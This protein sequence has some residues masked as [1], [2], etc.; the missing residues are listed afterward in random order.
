MEKPNVVFS[1]VASAPRGAGVGGGA[2]VGVGVGAVVGVGVGRGV[3]VG[4]TVGVTV[5]KGVAVGPADGTGDG[6]ALGSGVGVAEL[7]LEQEVMMRTKA[8]NRDKERRRVLPGFLIIVV[9][10]LLL[11]R[12]YLNTTRCYYRFAV[13]D[14]PQEGEEAGALKEE[15]MTLF[16]THHVHA[17]SDTAAGQPLL[18]IEKVS[19]QFAAR[20]GLL[21]RTIVRAVNDVSLALHRGETVAV[22][23]ESGSGKTTLGRASLGLVEPASGR[24][25]FDGKVV[26][27]QTESQRKWFRRRA[28]AVFQDPYS[29]MNAYMTVGQIVE[30]PLLV[31]G[32][33]KR[34]ERLARVAQALQ[35]VRLSPPDDFI[36]KYPHTLS[37]G[38][39]QRVGIARALVMRP[40]YI[41]AD[42][43]VSMIDAS[44]RAEVLYLMRDLQRR[45]GIAFLFITHDIASAAHFS[46]RVAVMYLGRIVELGPPRAVVNDPLHPYTR[47]LIE[48]VPEPDPANRLR[49][50]Q[51]VPG[52]PP[53]PSNLPAGCSFH[54]RC[55]RVIKGTCEAT[56]PPLQEIKPGHFAACYLYKT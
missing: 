50:R 33:G 48:A 34:E 40:E 42:E 51:V 10:F 13:Q 18:S 46:N 16:A 14:V 22:V 6:A 54:P 36:G 3:T 31:H 45:Y 47:A 56:V 25:T 49:M 41:V 24:V 29:S 52:E 4:R 27:G 2:V 7:P 11:C 30:E 55:P 9:P 26:T 19:V 21:G 43:P 39:R 15:K 38:Q 28:Q 53:S 8:E 12:L 32:M 1:Y 44:S 5:G 23:G 17:T 20:K 37:G 35:D